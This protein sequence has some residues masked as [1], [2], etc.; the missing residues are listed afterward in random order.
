MIYS[1]MQKK[2]SSPKVPP[3][4]NTWDDILLSYYKLLR[5]R[6]LISTAILAWLVGLG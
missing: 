6:G 1:S 2:V 4:P 3:L 5:R